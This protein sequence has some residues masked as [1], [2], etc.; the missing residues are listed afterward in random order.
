MLQQ[1]LYA[2]AHQSISGHRGKSATMALLKQRVWWNTMEEDVATWRNQCVQCIKCRD[3]SVVPRPLGIQL[4]PERVGEVISADYIYIGESGSDLKYILMLCDKL[5]RTVELIPTESATTIPMMD[6]LVSWGSRYGLPEWLITDGGPHFAN[7]AMEETMKRLGIN[8]HITLAYAPW[9]NGAIERVGKELLWTLRTLMDELGLEDLLVP[10]IQFTL[11]HRLLK[12]LGGK[13]PLLVMTGRQPKTAVELAIWQGV[14]L[15]TAQK[16][17]VTLE[18]Y[19][20]IISSLA[21]E[22][23][24]MQSE[25]I[26]HEAT[27][28]RKRRAKIAN[29]TSGY[30]FQMGDYVLVASQGNAVHVRRRHKAATTWQ[31]PYQIITSRNVTTIGVKMIGS[32]DKPKY[33]HWSQLKRF[34]GSEVDMPVA[35]VEQAQRAS[36]QFEVEELRDLRKDSDGRVEVLVHWK[37][38]PATYDSWE[39][40]TEIY[41]DIGNIALRF[42][43]RNMKDDEVFVK[44]YNNLKILKSR[45]RRK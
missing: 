45:R 7:M 23:D 3:G 11:N 20:E 4:L 43:E 42:L 14:M 26:N 8:H 16:K 2:T 32:N 36:V 29:K 22:I 34:C 13:S 41:K 39:S 5:S 15:A 6:T 27:S 30:Q 9:S 44:C 25:V 31:G 19:K 18:L 37:G 40:F 21:Y 38:F 12:S 24:K 35:I 28:V 10:L 33:V 17:R 1:G